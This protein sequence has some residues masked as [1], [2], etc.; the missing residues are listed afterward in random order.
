MYRLSSS[1]KDLV[2]NNYFYLISNHTHHILGQIYTSNI[3][4]NL[5][6]MMTYHFLTSPMLHIF[7]NDKQHSVYVNDLQYRNSYAYTIEVVVSSN[8]QKIP[9]IININDK[10]ITNYSTDYC[11]HVIILLIKTGIII[12]SV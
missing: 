5:S 11:L 6:I 9:E 4:K 2:Y 12:I 7:A 1:L 3:H 8:G 10:H